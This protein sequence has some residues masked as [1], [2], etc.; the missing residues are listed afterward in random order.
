MVGDSWERGAGAHRWELHG[1]HE[2]V[3]QSLWTAESP[4]LLG[5]GGYAVPKA[6]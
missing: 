2:W 5:P 6:P 1:T 3:G 4:C